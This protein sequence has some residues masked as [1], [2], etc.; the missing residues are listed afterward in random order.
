VRADLLL[1]DQLT[2]TLDTHEAAR[3]ALSAPV[4]GAAV[5][6]PARKPHALNIRSD[7]SATLPG[8]R[9]RSLRHTTKFVA[10]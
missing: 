1:V 5:G 8:I 10:R 3:G 6:A 4:R 9:N 2:P 7:G